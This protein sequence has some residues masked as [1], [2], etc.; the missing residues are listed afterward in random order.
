MD[1]RTAAAALA[2]AEVEYRAAQRAGDA[3]RYAAAVRAY[4]EAERVA[5][6]VLQGEAMSDEQRWCPNCKH[7]GKDPFDGNLCA[8]FDFKSGTR[9]YDVRAWLS[10][11]TE[12]ST[13]I[14]DDADN[15]P[16]FESWRVVR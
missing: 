8:L 14:R 15:C 2:K 5:V 1:P 10:E 12:A 9:R 3:A 11:N 13:R 6:E 16:G 4:R 7:F